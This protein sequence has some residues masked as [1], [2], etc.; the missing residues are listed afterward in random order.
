MAG[1]LGFSL[2]GPRAYDGKL[3]ELPAFGDGR[4]DLGARDI[5][6]ALQ[7]YGALLTI[8]FVVAVVVAGVVWRL[9]M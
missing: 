9:G 8:V 7:L 2:G 1:A 4:T 5:L 3:H 6:R